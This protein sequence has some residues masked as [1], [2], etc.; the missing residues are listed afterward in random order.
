MRT[1]VKFVLAC[2]AITA[3]ALAC[4]PASAANA[5]GGSFCL[6]YR[7]GGTDCGFTSLAQ[8][9]ASASGTDAGCYAAPQALL[10][11]QGASVSQPAPGQSRRTARVRRSE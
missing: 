2:G 8:C 1:S 10:Q 7:D 5:W 3:A 4:D 6:S 9:Q 11:Q